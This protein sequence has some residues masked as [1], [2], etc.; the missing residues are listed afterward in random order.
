MIHKQTEKKTQTYTKREKDTLRE[1][2]T[3]IE[4]DEKYIQTYIEKERQEKE[5]TFCEKEISLLRGRIHHTR[6]LDI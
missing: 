5:F 1:R 6:E 2:E 3:F 4:K